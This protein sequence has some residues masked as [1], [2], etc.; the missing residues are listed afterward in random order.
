MQAIINTQI[1]AIFGSCCQ[2][3]TE[4]EREREREKTALRVFA[5]ELNV[6]FMS[7]P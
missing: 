5:A 6:S 2:P 3:G 1:S 4:C 7:L